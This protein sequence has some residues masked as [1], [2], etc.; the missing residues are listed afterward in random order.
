MSNSI[1]WNAN[2]ERWELKDSHGHVLSFLDVMFAPAKDGKKIQMLV[3]TETLAGLRGK[4]L[5]TELVE[6]LLPQIRAHNEYVAPMCPFVL[7]KMAQTDKWDDLIP[8]DAQTAWGLS[9]P[10]L[11]ET[12]EQIKSGQ[13][14]GVNLPPANTTVH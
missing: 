9:K 11:L 10:G 6:G 14:P 8:P 7:I 4:G 12:F 13:V 5:A 1:N 3:H 2:L